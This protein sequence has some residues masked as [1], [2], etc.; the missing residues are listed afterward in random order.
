MSFIDGLFVAPGWY[1]DRWLADALGKVAPIYLLRGLP[2]EGHRRHGKARVVGDHRRL[3]QG[4]EAVD[5]IRLLDRAALWI[6][7]RHGFSLA[8][9]THMAALDH[10]WAQDGLA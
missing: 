9:L 1:Y 4:R 3:E 5:R 2:V 10:E 7:R 6:L 8:D